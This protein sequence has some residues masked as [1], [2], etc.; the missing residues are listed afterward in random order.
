MS[1]LPTSARTPGAARSGFTLV[2]LLVVIAIIALL[3]AILLPALS[4]AKEQ[5][6][7]V[8]CA[9]NLKQLGTAFQL[10]TS[11]HKGK[12]PAPGANARPEDWIWWQPTRDVN[13]GPLVKYFGKR[14]MA[15]VYVCPSDD[16]NTHINNANAYRYSYTINYN[17]TGWPFPGP[18]W[19]RQPTKTG[20][21]RQPATKIL[22][23][24]ESSETIDDGTWAPQHYASDGR[25]LLSNRHDRRQ[26]QSKDPNLGLGNVLFADFHCDFIERKLTLLPRY[27]DPRY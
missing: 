25:N 23:L 19:T 5:A 26:E 3:V 9:S 15:G 7:R 2:E 4:K 6:N 21:I 1:S 14:F 11:D 18:T 16:P 13:K 10:Y 20:Q 8:K 24:D 17:I 12:F 22:L 27:Y